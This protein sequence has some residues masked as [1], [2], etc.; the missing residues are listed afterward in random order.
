MELKIKYIN[1]NIDI[2]NITKHIYKYTHLYV[3]TL[4]Y[5]N[6]YIKIL[7]GLMIASNI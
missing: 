1:Y 4:K 5:I 7:D 6:T 3:C 2:Q